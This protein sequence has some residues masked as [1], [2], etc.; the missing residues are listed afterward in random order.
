[1]SVISKYDNFVR[2]LTVE[3]NGA[4]AED[5]AGQFPILDIIGNLRD[6][7]VKSKDH[8]SAAAMYSEAWD[9]MLAIVESG[10]AFKAGKTLALI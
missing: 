3:I 5:T 4:K 6:E 10:Q 9:K 7:S 2:Q 1:M 8:V